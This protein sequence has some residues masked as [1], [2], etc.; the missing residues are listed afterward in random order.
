MTALI[1]LSS[2]ANNFAPVLRIVD[3]LHQGV[4]LSLDR[5]VYTVGTSIGCDLV[6]GD[7]G[8]ADEHLCLRISDQSIAIEAVGGEVWVLCNG[9]R[10]IKIPLGSGHCA[11]MPM[12]VRIGSARLMLTLADVPGHSRTTAS[13]PAHRKPLWFVATLVTLLGIW[14][15]TLREEPAPVLAPTGFAPQIDSLIEPTLPTLTEA[16]L[17]LEQQ[18]KVG[19]FRSVEVT[20]IDAQLVAT[21]SFELTMKPQWAALQ[22]AYDQR[23]GHHVVLRSSV[24]ARAAIAQPRVRFQAVWFG[25]D[26]YVISDSGKRLYPGALLPD[27]WVLKHIENNEIILARGDELFRLTL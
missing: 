26:P 6:L 9:S 17:W 5:L 3:G 18:L 19:K 12:E 23:Y 4:S 13:F 22:K 7:P 21:G 11:R 15:L 14:A 20:E 2:P 24:S 16:R 8:I 1:S 27:N 10:P 25:T